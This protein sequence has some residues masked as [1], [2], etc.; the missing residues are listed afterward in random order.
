M[1]PPV[2]GP[3]LEPR[4]PLSQKQARREDVKFAAGKIAVFQYAAVLIFL[5]LITGFW[6]LQIQNPQIYNEQAERNRIKQLPIPAPRGKI[7]DRD[8]RVIVDNHSS[9]SLI[10][11]RENL[12]ME[13][14]HPI[15][16]G[17]SLDY[18]DLRARVQRYTS[19][20]KYDPII[21]KE[22]LTPAELSFVDSHRDFFPEMELIHA[23][24]RL[25]PQNGFAAHVIGYTGEISD[26][27]LD[28]PEFAKYNPGAVIGKFGVE[29]Q[30]NDLLTGVDGERQVVVD[31]RGKTREVLA[32]KEAVPGKDLQLTLDLDLQAVAE[33]AMEGK[34]GAVVAMDPRTGEVL[35]M[36]SR[37]TFDPNKFAVR[38]KS[39]D[40]REIADNPDHPLLNR[41][42]QAQD[43]PGSTFKPFVAMAGL[44]SGAI[45]DQ[46]TV[47]CS[48]GASFYGH[49]HKCHIK[50]GHGQ[51]SLH[52][53]IVQSC[54]VYFYNVGDRTGIDKIAFYAHQAGYGQK[55]GIDLPHEAE[56]IVPSSEWKIRNFREKWYAGETISVAIGQGA[57]TVT[58]IQQA[59]AYSWLINGGL[60]HQPHLV[61][62][63]KYTEHS[64]PVSADNLAKVIYGTYGVV[65][66]G[67]TGGRARLPGIEVCGKTG[68]A[69]LASDEFLK[70][71]KGIEFANNAWFVGFAPWHAPEIVVVALFE[72]GAEGPLAAPIVRDVLKAYFDKKAR[73]AAEAETR[74]RGDA[75]KVSRLMRFG[76]PEFEPDAA[77]PESGVIEAGLIGSD[78]ETGRYGN[79]ERI[80]RSMRLSL[81]PIAPGEPQPVSPDDGETRVAASPRRRVSG[82]LLP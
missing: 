73:L 8:G 78:M 68:T 38:I 81:P 50:T 60:W 30:Y 76:L 47:H 16:E 5:F 66:E 21:I 1:N 32:N 36:V 23:Q 2:I 53:G 6:V 74:R 52:K 70:G 37:P 25:Y 61:K 40:W 62:G 71:K 65:N 34:N 26:Q 33:L 27:E 24:R 41:A 13:H 67:G 58:P 28:S 14:L 15:A 64:W 45:D 48:G 18:D 35:A 72:H 46:F 4:E 3:E 12:N 77:Q 11:S 82:S 9:Y 31:S 20:P 59:R 79:A 39:S 49:Y 80:S 10:L 54:D 57:V 42:I 44:E 55:T 69:Q 7:L 43:A 17:L 22:E 75:E 19:R 56:G 29:R 51:V 63:G